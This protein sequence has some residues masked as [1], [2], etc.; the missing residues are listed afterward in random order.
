MDQKNLD[1]LEN[2]KRYLADG[3]GMQAIENL[4]ELV[5]DGIDSAILEIGNIYES[6][7]ANVDQ[8]LDK[9][10]SYYEDA[11]NK[12]SDPEALLRL[13]RIYLYAR[14][15]NESNYHEAMK[16]YGSESLSNDST[17][18]LNLGHIYEN[19]L[20][21]GIDFNKASELYKR[22]AKL[23]SIFARIYLARLLWKKNKYIRSVI[24]RLTASLVALIELFHDQENYSK[25][26]RRN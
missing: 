4:N 16:I 18:I 22:S 15:G 6:G 14:G 1:K 8:D 24:T 11:Y 5:N 7:I 2:F 17:A 9:A 23:G 10:I 26:I 21:V 13:A 20:G 19:G 3:K 12:T 25:K